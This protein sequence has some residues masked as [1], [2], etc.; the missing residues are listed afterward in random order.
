MGAVSRSG[1]A[2]LFI[3]NTAEQVMDAL[4]CDLLVVKPPRF[5]SRVPQARRGVLFTSLPPI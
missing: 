3:G 1:L 4:P 2:R 5:K